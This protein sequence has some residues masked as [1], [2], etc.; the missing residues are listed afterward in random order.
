MGGTLG[1]GGGGGGLGFGA[2]DANDSF[3]DVTATPG[4]GGGGSSYAPGGTTGVSSA[5]ASVTI[6]FV[7]PTLGAPTGVAA[8][9]GD[10][11]ATVSWV[12]PASQPGGVTGYTVTATNVAVPSDIV[13]KT[14]GGTP[15][16]TSTT[17]TGLLG[18]FEYEVRVVATNATSTSLPSTLTAESL[19]TP[20]QKATIQG[21][22]PN[23]TVGQPYSFAFDRRGVPLPSVA[24]TAGTI[25]PGLTLDTAT[26][27]ETALT[28]TPT[29]AGT[30]SFSLTVSN[31]Y[32]PVTLPVTLT[33][34]GV[35]AG[36]PT[37]VTAT[38]GNASALIAWVAPASTGGTALTGYGVAATDISDPTAAPVTTNVDALVLSTVVPGLTPAHNYTFRVVA[39]NA[40]GSSAPSAIAGPVTPFAPPT[41]A[42]APATVT[43]G[44][45]ASFAFTVTG[46]PS[47][48]VT[49]TSGSL[50]AGM[51]VSFAGVLS[52]T[53]TATGVST[54]TL[55]ASNGHSPAASVTVQLTVV[56]GDAATISP[57]AGNTQ[58]ATAGQAFA[59]PLVA[60]VLDANANPVPVAAV[61]FT[62]TSGTAS[63]PSGSSVTV[64]SDGAGLA[65]APLLN[66]GGT[67]GA[68]SVLA[69]SGAASAAT[70]TE[71]V[72]A[73]GPAR[74][75]LQVT[76]A[77]PAKVAKG[78]T[79]TTTVTVRNVGPN[80]AG[81][82][83][84][85][86]E[87][88]SNLTIVSVSSGVLQSG[89][90]LIA[91]PSLPLNATLTYTVTAR[92]GT[93]S[94][95]ARLGAAAASATR[96]PNLLNNAALASIV[97][98]P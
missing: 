94:A 49:V 27:A 56:A 24:L 28:G 98:G 6:T 22:P 50:P 39:V 33:V 97:V 88:G 91:S 76:I 64:F 81:A 10:R 41:I 77:A 25:P 54:F 66:A 11:A 67:A 90:A 2:S 4:G 45:A 59:S 79:F 68:V 35:V 72:V 51:S 18:G 44:V 70:F 21:T 63:F 89:S 85:V 57:S 20:D 84:T 19:V 5:A 23:G 38:A 86:I 31:G 1:G 40:A 58:T 29:S 9:A 55:T 17:V 7:T 14:V 87:P 46:A 47:P 61:T 62:V 60:L 48:T 52:G 13:T 93:R 92:A 83:L 42:G 82:L 37:N 65:T 73:A 36:P 12:A 78:T 71:T 96:D 3:Y 95:T 69:T 74:A 32:G 16:A 30:W 75:D 34:T 80:A 8:V 26:L 43:A 53:P 15:P